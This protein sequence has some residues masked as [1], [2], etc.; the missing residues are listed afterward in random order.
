MVVGR[1]GEAPGHHS[2]LLPPSFFHFSLDTTWSRGAMAA[3]GGRGRAGAVGDLRRRVGVSARERRS[4]GLESSS[5]SS[6]GSEGGDA[7]I[8]GGRCVG[9]GRGD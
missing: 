1:G 6:S 8:D 3:S 9:G 5:R 4:G 7:K 2:F